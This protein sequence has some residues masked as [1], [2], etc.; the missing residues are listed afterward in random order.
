MLPSI[1][2]TPTLLIAPIEEKM[3][4]FEAVPNEGVHC[5]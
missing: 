2:D 3:V 5:A 4:K 1:V